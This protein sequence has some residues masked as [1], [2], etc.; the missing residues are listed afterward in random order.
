MIVA[1][2]PKQFTLKDDG[3]IY[4]QPDSTNPLPGDALALVKKGDGLLQPSVSLIEG[5]DIGAEDPAAVLTAV[6]TWMKAHIYTVLEPLFSLVTDDALAE[7]V[8]EIAL[9]LFQ[10]TGIVP[11]GEVEDSISKLDPDM[12]KAL[13]DKKVRL[14]PLL[15]FLPDLNKPAAVKLR[16]ILWSLFNDKP[17]PAPTPRDGAMSSVVDV[18]TADAGFYRAIG[19]PLYGPRVIRI[20]MLD[21]VINA[22][23]DSA[24]EGKFQAQHKMAEWMGCPIADLYAILEAMGH[25]HI[26]KPVDD[27]VVDKP[28][29]PDEPVV[30]VV[31]SAPSSSPMSLLDIMEAPAVETLPAV[32]EKKAEQKKP[33]LDWF[34]LRRGKAHVVQG[35]RPPRTERVPRKE[36]T[37]PD[38][39]SAFP[40]ERFAPKGQKKKTDE[41]DDRQKFKKKKHDDRK[42]EEKFSNH[43]PRVYSADASVSDNPF[44]VLQ[45]LKLK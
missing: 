20:D 27:V 29:V 14:G 10:H 9:K 12:R 16:A 24:K 8:K 6:E 35:E 26:V 31:E 25:K 2:Q 39:K 42:R 18:T 17:L 37:K 40:P 23:Y 28:V 44:S 4:F 19:Y 32:E 7:P 38:K 30:A 5:R 21:R 41:G 3:V 15:V 13:R 36:F 33:E 34:F 1:A 45:N 22:I 43:N 11:R